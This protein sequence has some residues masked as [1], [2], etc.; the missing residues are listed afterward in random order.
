MLVMIT[1]ISQIQLHDD[2]SQDLLPPNFDILYLHN[3][4]YVTGSHLCNLIFHHLMLP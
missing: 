2:L 3:V 1:N 4:F